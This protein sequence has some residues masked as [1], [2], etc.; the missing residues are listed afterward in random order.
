M[1]DYQYYEFQT[2]GRQ[3]GDEARR[4]V[5]ALSAQAQISR[6][7]ASFTYS[8]GDFRGD[9]MK[10]L[11][12]HFDAMLYM[13]NWGSRQLAFQFPIC[14][15]DFEALRRFA[16]SKTIRVSKTDTHALV[17]MFLDDGTGPGGLEGDGALGQVIGLYEDLIE[18]DYRALFLLWLQ[19]AS[20]EE[21][22]KLP[23]IPA[24]LG[25]LSETHRTFIRYFGIDPNLAAAAEIFSAPMTQ[26]TNEDLARKL[27][28]M[29]VEQSGFLRRM[30]M[31]ES[32]TIVIAELRRRL[33]ANGSSADD[34][35][36]PISAAFLFARARQI[37]ANR[38]N[39]AKPQ[40]Q[41]L[42]VS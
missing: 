23:S 16:F 31:G 34:L 40:E 19:A 38:G 5:S 30:V 18:G 9:P 20:M 29:G 8:Y 42:P 32:P 10:L 11:M 13:A 28:S 12:R 27:D 36:A 26:L 3:L 33:R 39:E 22:S 4:E 17:D 21:G 24:G 15:V 14:S 37:Q 2:V 1:N 35:P 6:T 25:E 7:S 41:D